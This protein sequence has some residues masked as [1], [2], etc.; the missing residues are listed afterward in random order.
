MIYLLICLVALYLPSLSNYFSGDD[1]FHLRISQI[2]SMGEFLNFFSFSQNAQSASFFRPLPTQ[3]FFF[4]FQK[5]FGLNPVPYHILVLLCFGLSLYL[6]YYF[7]LS[8]FKKST[9]ALVA[10]FVYGISAS[11]FTRVYFLSAFQEICLV[12]FSLLCLI[13]FPHKKI[14]SFL[15]FMLALLSKETAVVLPILL[16]VLYLRKLSGL[17]AYAPFFILLAGYLF[18]RFQIFGVHTEDSYSWDFSPI[19]ALN[20]ISWY[21]LWSVGIPEYLVDYVRDFQLIPKFYIDFSQSWKIQLPLYVLT[22]MGIL[23]IFI[24]K[25]RQIPSQFFLGLVVFI[26]SL[27]PVVFLPEHKFSLELGL[28][29]V[30]FSMMIASICSKR[31]NITMGSFL[32][33]LTILNLYTQFLTYPRHYS[34]GR[35]LIAHKVNSYLTQKY[36]EYPEGRI[37]YFINDGLTDNPSWGQSRQISLSLSGSDFFKVFYKNKKI[38]VYYQDENPAIVDNKSLIL[39]N[40]QQFL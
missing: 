21:S 10:M 27:S 28:P 31:I 35:G 3:V 26:V 2:G 23:A 25:I 36:P 38:Q 37:F 4:I 19:R 12:I 14:R 13:S 15:F 20:T 11:N 6:V 30:G 32:L 33:I 8:I 1:W 24:S 40:S 34:I 39:I 7:S 22:G 9:P 17:K 29:L 18:L 5:L 16:L